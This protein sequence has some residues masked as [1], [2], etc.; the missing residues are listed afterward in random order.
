MD[1]KNLEAVQPIE[2]VIK[3]DRPMV[4]SLQIAENFGKRHKDVLRSIEK[5]KDE[6][7]ELFVSAILRSRP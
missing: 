2:L 5:A 3:H 6:T 7:S 1:R 4:S